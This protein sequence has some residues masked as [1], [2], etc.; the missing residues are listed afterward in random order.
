MNQDD[1]KKAE[2][3][4]PPQTP[5]NESPKANEEKNA[6]VQRRPPSKAVFVWLIIFALIGLFFVLKSLQNPK[7]LNC[8]QSTFEKMLVWGYVKSAKISS[9][10]D[11]LM[12]VEGKYSFEQS[13][14][15]KTVNGKK[16]SAG[17]LKREG[18]RR[19]AEIKKKHKKINISGKYK[20]RVLFSERL[21]ALLKTT[22]VDVKPKDN[23]WTLL[24]GIIPIVIIVG[25]I[26]FLFSRQI[27]GAGRGAMQF[28]K[29][30]ARMILPTDLNI[31]F[32]DIAGADEAKEETKEII[33]F[34]AD[35]LKFQMLGG[36]V[37]KGFLL[38]GPPGTGKTLLAK[39]VA[40]EAKV[41]FFSISGSDFV[42][43]FVGVGASRVRD[44]FE[45]ARKNLPCLIFVDEIDA[46]GRSRFSGM[47][48]GHDEREQTLNAMLVEMDGL[49]SSPGVIVLAATNRPD[50]LDPALLRPGRFDR[51]IV[52]DLPDIVGRHH[53]LEVHSKNIR[54][55]ENINIDT[56]AK[57]TPGF[58]G[59][60]LANLCNEAALLAA[61]TNSE[62]ISQA[63]M[64][65]AR[66]KVRW[67]R[68]RRSR[69]IT[70][71]ERKLTAYHEAGHTLV[72]MHSE[73]A[74]PVH[75]VTIIPR[76]QAY[77][78]ATMTLPEEDT[79]TQSKKELIDELAV[80]MGGRAAEDLIFQD[81]T[82]GASS[83]IERAS[84]LAR[85]MV[86]RFGMNNVIGPVQ[87]GETH[88]QV[89]VRTDSI[90]QDSYGPEVANLIDIEVKKTIDAANNK[91]RKILKEHDDQLEAIAQALLEKETLTVA[92]VREILNMPPLEE[93]KPA[94]KPAKKSKVKSKAETEEDEHPDIIQRGDML[95][96]QVNIT[97]KTPKKK[98][99]E[100]NEEA[101]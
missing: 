85:M 11:R 20:T 35:P 55:G 61:R 94:V 53:I 25:V 78:G 59:A 88:N 57:T 68:E 8:D 76:G 46:V 48:G 80:L 64:E 93:T 13:P 18:E 60:D 87:Y 81:V 16:I 63:D 97:I 45:Q 83:D 23:W 75:K 17:E 29:S 4:A 2:E 82:T 98:Q 84:H 65:E 73:F 31:T 24:V 12:A 22:A 86:C 36:R 7:T 66:D 19:F 99:E 96:S 77:L 26:Y 74:T 91:A 56:I 54:L 14:S 58:S 32:D 62:T 38:T 70:D 40:C 34:L 41:P 71:R 49:E 50:V 52:L 27:K 92:E 51:Q 43:M 30:R 67:G 72:V 6:V 15:I 79:Y 69:R 21:D 3:Q 5:Q 9:E 39:A 1:N 28:G 42:E 37:P 95:E 10:T 101:S 100:D 47:G 89:H 44:M 90:P 33:D